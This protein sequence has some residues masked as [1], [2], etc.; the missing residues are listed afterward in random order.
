MK[1]TRDPALQLKLTFPAAFWR[2]IKHSLTHTNTKVKRCASLSYDEDSA[3]IS[4]R[5]FLR[6]LVVLRLV[7]K[8]QLRDVRLER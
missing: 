8:V 3:G 6:V 5:R 4:V 2:T 7:L 1:A